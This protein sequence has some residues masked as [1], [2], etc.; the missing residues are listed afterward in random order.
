[1]LQQSIGARRRAVSPLFVHLFGLLLLLAGVLAAVPQAF[2]QAMQ[3]A[4]GVY[5]PSVSKFFLDGNFDAVVDLKLIFGSPGVTDVGLVGDLAG[6][7][8]RYPVIYRNG[9]WLVD[10]NKDGVVDQTSVSAGRRT[11]SR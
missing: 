2:G 11:T 3:A 6:A 7:G 5:R 1:M 8:T 9:A 4:I 10:F